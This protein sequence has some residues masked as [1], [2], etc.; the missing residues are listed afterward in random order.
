MKK[1]RMNKVILIIKMKKKK[2]SNNSK[3]TRKLMNLS[4]ITAKR[5]ADTSCM[6]YPNQEKS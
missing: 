4:K 3:M 6:K 5:R 2:T 1:M